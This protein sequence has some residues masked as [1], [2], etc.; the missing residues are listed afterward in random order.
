[1][2]PEQFLCLASWGSLSLVCS[3]WTVLEGG[4]LRSWWAAAK[5]S[6]SWDTFL[7]SSDSHNSFVLS[8]HALKLNEFYRGEKESFILEAL[9]SSP[10]MYFPPVDFRRCSSLFCSEC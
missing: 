2:N 9:I 6:S 5:S 8:I 4:T 1:M 7:K 10:Q 3:V